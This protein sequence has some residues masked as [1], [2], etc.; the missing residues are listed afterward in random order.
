[1]QD[2]LI[3]FMSLAEGKSRVKCGPL[4]LHT[5]TAI[6]FSQSI[7]GAQ[8]KVTELTSNSNIIECEGIGYRPEI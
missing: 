5:K 8:F 7:T 2:Q 4:T 6:H 3:I 1:M